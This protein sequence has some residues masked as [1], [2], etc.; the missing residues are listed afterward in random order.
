MRLEWTSL[1]KIDTKDF[2]KDKTYEGVYIWGFR[3]E[4]EYIPYYIGEA[5]NISK[6]ILEHLSSLMSGHYTIYDK[7][8]LKFFHKSEKKYGPVSNRSNNFLDFFIRRK[9]LAEHIDF[10]LDTFE[11]S[12]AEVEG[13]KKSRLDVEKYLIGL[14]GT[15]FIANMKG[16]KSEI[17][18]I[19]NEGDIELANILNKLT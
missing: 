14:F 12:F 17:M 3:I 8:H 16:G 15:K 9:E 6:R 5:G 4:G 10:M 11:F 18:N 13:G 7:K 19:E 1:A 2:L